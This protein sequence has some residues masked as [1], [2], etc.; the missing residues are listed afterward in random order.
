MA[1]STILGMATKP[2]VLKIERVKIGELNLDTNNAR[3]HSSK[4]VDAIKQ[5]MEKFGQ[6]TP[7]VV[8]QNGIVLA[9]NG[10]LEAAK[11]LGWES[12]LVIKTDLTGEAARAFAIADN[13]SSELAEWDEAILLAQLNEISQSGNAYFKGLGFT[14]SELEAL[15]KKY[16]DTTDTDFPEVDSELP[17]KHTCPSCGFK[18]G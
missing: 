2:L 5:S 4:N 12:I 3:K 1:S 11:A 14:E 15:Q 16:S 8:D 18:W 17:V 7:I 13:R 9:G 6:Q 10:R